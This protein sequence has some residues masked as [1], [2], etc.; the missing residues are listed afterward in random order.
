MKLLVLGA[1]GAVGSALVDRALDAGHEV[2]GA[3]R[4]I[5]DD[6]RSH[7]AFT[8]RQVDLLEGGLST[9]LEGVDA[10]ASTVGLPRSP[11]QLADPPPLFTEGMVNLIEGMRMAGV[12]RL[13][14]VSAAFVERDLNIPDWFRAAILPLRAQFREMAN[15]ERI[16]RVAEDIDWTAVRPGWLLDRDPTADYTVDDEGLPPGTL[17]ARHGDVAHFLLRCLAEDSYI[18]E[19]PFIARSEAHELESPAALGEELKRGFKL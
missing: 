8:A 5:D 14:A 13:V 2:V 7:P 12:R 19:T 10:V 6:F 16:L 9:A 17:R 18:R 1:T 3:E 11:R 15:M 4:D